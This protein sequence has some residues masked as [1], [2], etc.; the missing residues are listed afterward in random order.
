M[1][2]VTSGTTIVDRCVTGAG[3]LAQLVLVAGL[4]GSRLCIFANLVQ[5]LHDKF[6]SLE[7]DALPAADGVDDLLAVAQLAEIWRADAEYAVCTSLVSKLWEAFLALDTLESDL[8]G[9]VDAHLHVEHSLRLAREWINVDVQEPAL[10][11]H[12]QIMRMSSILLE[13][14]ADEAR[15]Y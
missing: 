2:W 15:R 1:T 12:R 3:S 14:F 13:L 5:L 9:W 7:L 6:N 10:R 8:A 4:Q 11:Q